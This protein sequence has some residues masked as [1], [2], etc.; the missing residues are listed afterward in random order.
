MED[1]FVA[2]I[3]VD[4][5]ATHDGHAHLNHVDFTLPSTREAMLPQSNV[6]EQSFHDLR[7]G[8]KPE[9]TM[10]YQGAALY[11]IETDWVMRQHYH[12]YIHEHRR[13]EHLQQKLGQKRDELEEMRCEPEHAETDRRRQQAERA[14]VFDRSRQ[15][16]VFARLQGQKAAFDARHLQNHSLALAAEHSPGVYVPASTANVAP[17]V[18]TEQ[19]VSARTRRAALEPT[20]A[21]AASAIH[22]IQNP[23][24]WSN[25]DLC[26]DHDTSPIKNRS[27]SSGSPTRDMHCLDDSITTSPTYR[28]SPAPTYRLVTGNNRDGR[29][30]IAG[31]HAEQ[32]ARHSSLSQGGGCR[33]YALSAN[34]SV[35]AQSSHGQIENGFHAPPR[36]GMIER[37]QH[38]PPARQSFEASAATYT[39]AASSYSPYL[40]N[41]M[42]ERSR[43]ALQQ[44]TTEI[45]GDTATEATP[46]LSS[47]AHAESDM[48]RD[49]PEV[50]VDDAEPLSPNL[51]DIIG[52]ETPSEDDGDDDDEDEDFDPNRRGT[53]LVVPKHRE[54]KGFGMRTRRSI[55][56]AKR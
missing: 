56:R 21:S 13:R 44:T 35:Q 50:T 53:S 54:V 28:C 51:S 55:G 43:A 27:T 52:S 31:L 8:S 5:R 30:G 7:Y 14:A 18:S 9:D 17:L 15:Q 25:A 19:P 36:T 12:S 26:S 49:D 20:S 34:E 33:R 23:G 29:P 10:T 24:L 41:G 4:P 38:G 11:K 47:Y 42:I 6:W 32:C 3:A 37:Q 1:I 46:P 39:P 40:D 48:V 22:G 45:M 2:D 16:A